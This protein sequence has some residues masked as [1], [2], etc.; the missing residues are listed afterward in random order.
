LIFARMPVAETEGAVLAHSV[1]AGE[2]R[3]RKGRVLSATD[4]AALDAAGIATVM[5]ARLETGDVPEDEA[6]QR[7]AEALQGAGARTNAAFTGRCNL[8]AAEAGVL[9]LDAP[10]IEAIN[11]ID[12]SI[13]VA[14][15]PAFEGVTEGQM[16]A[17]VKIIPFAA[18]SRHVEAAEATAREGG[19]AISV[20]AFRPHKV[21]LVATRL[22]ETTDKLL[23]KTVEAIRHRV[24]SLGSELAA[25]EIC[26]HH[27][28][29][30]ATAVRKQADAGCEPVIVFAASAITDRADSI[31]A[32]I[33]AAGG[34]I[35]HFGM[36]V[37]PGNLLLM[38][39]LGEARVL[40]APGCARSP[41]LNGFDWVLQRLLAGLEV[42]PR[43]L[44]GMGV[45]G[46]LKE[47]GSRPQPRGEPAQAG[48]RMPRIAALV[49][50]AGQSRRMGTRNKLLAEI[51]GEPMLRRAV[52]AAMASQANDVTVVTGHEASAV[53]SALDGL[54][55]AFVHNPDYES[56][57]ST[58][59]AAGIR[60]LTGR[61]D[62]DGAVVLLGDMPGVTARHIDRL[63]A[64]FNPGEGRAICVPTSQ[65]KR[66]NPVLWARAFFDEIAEV[67]GDVG[68]KHLIGENEELVCEVEFGDAGPLDDIDTPEAL[69]AYT[70]PTS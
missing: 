27:E 12:E 9:L 48:P 19:R 31:P 60:S 64:A 55:V 46:L 32:G 17:T 38:A 14:T 63:I 68:A 58:S 41:K 43:E 30:V 35:L 54:G 4:I 49:L 52:E 5:A 11:G 40:G 23:N 6:A 34:E 3:F 47:I 39:R 36:P 56:G 44:T 57:L 22:P 53:R 45:G 24:V 42:G 26:D 15:L 62:I 65:G 67:A 29:A 7:I 18:A 50:A 25:T 13:T 2:Q 59:L 69:S 51:E 10:C 1:R 20:A 33:V 21:G 70:E 37:D 61:D 66:G 16:L 28:D 8:Y